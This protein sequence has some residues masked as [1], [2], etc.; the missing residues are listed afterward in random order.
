MHKGP[1]RTQIEKYCATPL[2]ALPDRRGRFGPATRTT[3]LSTEA[4]TQSSNKDVT[5]VLP[6]EGMEETSRA[7]DGP[8]D[9]KAEIRTTTSRW[10]RQKART[11]AATCSSLEI[12]VERLVWICAG[13]RQG[14]ARAAGFRDR[15]LVGRRAVPVPNPWNVTAS[16]ST[17]WKEQWRPWKA[18]QA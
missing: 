3:A 5:Y 7:G 4:C 6:A 17:L 16:K 8:R 2:K 14:G 11:A 18:P 15:N 12:D 13:I 10:R 9:T 1:D